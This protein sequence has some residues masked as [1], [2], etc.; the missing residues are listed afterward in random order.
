MIKLLIVM[1]LLSVGLGED[2]S[3]PIVCYGMGCVR[4]R[5]FEGNLKA[6]EGFFGIP[7]VKQPVGEL[8][9]RVSLRSFWNFEEK[10]VFLIFD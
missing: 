10:I 7:Y 9:L 2:R 3:D 8:R 1:G 4:G 5:R 6:F